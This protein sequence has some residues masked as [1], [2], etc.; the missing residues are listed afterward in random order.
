MPGLGRAQLLVLA[1][2]LCASCSSDRPRALDFRIQFGSPALAGRAAR[3]EARILLAGCDGDEALYASSFAPDQRGALPEVLANGRYGFDARALDR[4]CRWY[5][6][7]CM[8][9]SL[10]NSGDGSALVTLNALPS[11]ALDCASDGCDARACMAEADAAVARDAGDMDAASADGAPRDAA[12]ADDEDATSGDASLPVTIEIE[13]ESADPLRAPLMRIDDPMVSGGAYISYPWT[14]DQTLDQRNM[15]KRAEP[16][17]DDS[18]DGLAFY[19]FE[20]PAG[21]DFRLWGRV[22]PPTLEEDSFWLRIDDQPW[23]QWNDIAHET[24][25]H[26]D[27]VRPFENRNERF[28]ITLAPGAHRLLISYRELGARLDKLLLTSDAELVPSG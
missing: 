22:N 10:P 5:A 6:H 3:I 12:N 25:W 7:G 21:G 13:A 14:S 23:V 19:A 28:L 9:L 1:G 4:G 16:P 11:P 24:P 15:L 17:A 27:D 20:L 26:W 18:A 8:E 2:A